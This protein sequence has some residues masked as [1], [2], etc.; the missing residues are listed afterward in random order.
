[1]RDNKH[2]FAVFFE[3]LSQK[4]QAKHLVVSEKV[5]VQRIGSILRLQEGDDLILFDQTVHIQT[6]IEVINKKTVSLQ[7]LTFTQN[8]VFKPNITVLLPILKRDALESAIYSCTALGATH[9]QLVETGKTRKWQ[10]QKELD[11]LERLVIAAAEQSKNFSF[12]NVLEPCSLQEALQVHENSVHKL[13]ADPVGNVLI[14]EIQKIKKE[15][16]VL[17]GPEGDLTTNE[18]QL[19]KQEFNFCRLTP[20]ILKSEQALALLVGVLRSLT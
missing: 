12:P 3:G 18:K 11:R 13:F 14:D 2:H 19:I 17:V 6:K 15:V 20:T 1:M 16:I 4:G 5:F 9:I 8:A 10:G 7:I